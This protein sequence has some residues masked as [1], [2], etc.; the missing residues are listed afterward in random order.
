MYN[1]QSKSTVN[2][3][4][5]TLVDFAIPDTVPKIREVDLHWFEFKGINP[6]YLTIL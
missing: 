4:L 1:I 2:L 6:R 3:N 5:T